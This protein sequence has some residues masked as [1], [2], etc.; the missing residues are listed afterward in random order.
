MSQQLETLAHE[1]FADTEN[2]DS[3]YGNYAFITPFSDTDALTAN[4][5]FP[6]SIDRRGRGGKLEILGIEEFCGRII[7]NRFTEEA[8]TTDTVQ[9]LKFGL[10]YHLATLIAEQRANAVGVQA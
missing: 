1:I 2:H 6:V 4:N 5:D 7:T 8:L 3:A 10:T 9:V